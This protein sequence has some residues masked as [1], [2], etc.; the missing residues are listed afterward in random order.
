[1]WEWDVSSDFSCDPTP[2]QGC[3]SSSVQAMWYM[4]CVNGLIVFNYRARCLG[5]DTFR[6]E[7]F[8]SISSAYQDPLS[9]WFMDTP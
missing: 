1:M 3:V 2:S 5:V 6:N 9:G 8:K 7:G 4:G